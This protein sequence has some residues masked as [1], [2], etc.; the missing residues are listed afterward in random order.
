[1]NIQNTYEKQ[2]W[3]IFYHCWYWTTIY[4]AGIFVVHIGIS[5]S[6]EFYYL[7]SKSSHIFSFISFR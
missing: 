1:M 4:Q 2:I 7:I 3:T 6:F 5:T